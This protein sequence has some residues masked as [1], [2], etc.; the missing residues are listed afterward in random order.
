[1]ISIILALPMIC[2]GAYP[3]VLF[4]GMGDACLMPGMGGIKKHL[5]KY[6]PTECVESA[7][8]VA[9]IVGGSFLSQCEAACEKVK[10]KY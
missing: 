8:S 3:T 6:M 7:P 5:D 2:L 4:H 1:M 9:S 10:E